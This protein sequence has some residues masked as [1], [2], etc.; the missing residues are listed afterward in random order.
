[1]KLVDIGNQNCVETY[2]FSFSGDTNNN[3]DKPRDKGCRICKEE[4]H[5]ARD[6]PEKGEKG[7]GDG[8]KKGCFKC[9]GDHMAADCEQPDVCRKVSL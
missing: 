1:M 4:G 8:E 2:F 9:G 5:F 6:C 3:D 7:D